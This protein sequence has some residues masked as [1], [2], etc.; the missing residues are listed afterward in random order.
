M[1]RILRIIVVFL[2]LSMQLTACSMTTFVNPKDTY[3]VCKNE[4]TMAE[5]IRYALLKHKWGIEEE[6]PGVI[7]AVM[8]YKSFMVKVKIVYWSNRMSIYYKDSK[9]LGY[10]GK[11]ISKR[12]Y[13]WINNISR[14][15]RSFLLQN[16]AAS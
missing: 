9:N 3:L 14:S 15:T 7:I 13:R 1:T 4:D 5:A 2:V 16:H 12:Y 10:D 11:E 6:A 8:Q